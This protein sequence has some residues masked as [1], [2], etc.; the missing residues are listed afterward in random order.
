MVAVT[1]SRKENENLISAYINLAKDI[2]LPL[3]PL[4]DP[5]KAFL[6]SKS[7]TVLGVD[8]RTVD[9]TWRVPSERA[10]HHIS[11]IQSLINK[12][13]LTLFN[14][15]TAAGMM[16]CVESMIPAVKPE[17]APIKIALR[18]ANLAKVKNNPM[19]R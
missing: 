17:L 19:F 18:A 7:G 16:V 2:N 12:R 6:F 11:F 15:Q 8:F 13:F 9:N 1:W 4:S 14:L 5:D 3:A 10:L